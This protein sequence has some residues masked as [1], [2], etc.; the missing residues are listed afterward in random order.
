M[1]EPESKVA[2]LVGASGLAGGHL[3]DALLGAPDFARVYAVTRR[4][5]GREHARLANRIIQ[6]DRLEAQLKGLAC[7]T[8][9]CCLGVTSSE[10]ARSER[11]VR[12]IELD[13]VLAFAKVART[14]GA[15]RFVFL[16]CVGADSDS[17]SASLRLKR[18]AED[19]L[20]ALGFASLDILQPGPLIGMR[21]EISLADMARGL[22]ALAATP[23]LFGAR[24]PYRAISVRT[25]AAAMLGAVRSG[26][27]GVYRYTHSAIRALASSR[28]RPR[29]A[30]A[31]ASGAPKPGQPPRKV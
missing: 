14:G 11:A 10:A 15:Q 3:L 16:S 19:A 4:P 20:E 5:L 17:R 8:A 13:Y 29:S 22:A 21:R 12:Q 9:F 24:E 7:H 1:A 26:R 25:V 30:P 18:E 31:P 28:D 2:V 6:F 23:L 27:R